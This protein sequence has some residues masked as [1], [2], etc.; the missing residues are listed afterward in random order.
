MQKGVDVNLNFRQRGKFLQEKHGYL[1][2]FIMNLYVTGKDNGKGI[3]KVLYFAEDK[4]AIC[5]GF[6]T[7]MVCKKGN[8]K[9]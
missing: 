3:T 5:K 9:I 4:I 2:K 6:F 7:N 1:T 8:S